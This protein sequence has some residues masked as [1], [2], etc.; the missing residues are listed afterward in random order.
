MF[1]VL[2]LVGLL[3]ARDTGGLLGAGDTGAVGCRAETGSSGTSMA[4]SA[5]LSQVQQMAQVAR[6]FSDGVD[7]AG[8]GV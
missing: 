7:F 5:N 2:L 1:S 3:S 4:V 6:F 8:T